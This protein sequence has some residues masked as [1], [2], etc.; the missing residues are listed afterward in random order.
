MGDGASLH[1]LSGAVLFALLAGGSAS[2]L[3]DAPVE[4]VIY[5]FCPQ[6]ANGSCVDGQTPEDGVIMDAS[7]NLYGIT[8]LGGAQNRGTVYKLTSTASG[9]DETVLY[10]F[11]G[12]GDD[13]QSTAGLVM[14]GS[15]NLYWTSGNL[16]FELSPNGT[17]WAEKVI[18]TFP[19][20]ASGASPRIALIDGLGSL[21][22][23]TYQGGI[24]TSGA[25]YGAGTA[26]KMTPS[27]T[28][29]TETVLYSFCQKTNCA[30][31]ANPNALLGDTSGNFYGTT[32]TGGAYGAG[33]VFKL[34][35]SGAA[36]TETVLYSFC[37]QT[38]CP[39][40]RG[41]ANLLMDGAGNLYGTAGNGGGSRANGTV[42]MLA[43]SGS[44]W[45][46]TVLYNFACNEGRANGLV[47]DPAG[48]LYGTTGWVVASCSSYGEIYKLT[49]TGSGWTQTII[50]NPLFPQ[51]GLLADKSGNIYGTA[52]GGYGFGLCPRGCG[53][54]YE[55][56]SSGNLPPQALSVSIGGNGKGSLASSPA[57]I[58]C[59]APT[60]SGDTCSAN[61]PAGTIVTLSASS[62]SGSSFAGWSGACA[63]TGSCQVTMNQ[64][65]T[66]SATF[67]S[68][69]SIASLA[70]SLI[71]RG[72]V[73]SSPSGISCPNTC[74]ASYAA[75]SN[76][77]LTAT[78]ANGW[79]FRGWSG[80]CSGT[81]ACSV[82]M[83]SNQSAS[84]T[85][86]RWRAGN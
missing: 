81:D 28:G 56:T 7:G 32:S 18:Y 14:D 57:G 73:T 29:W 80:A 6:G 30:D 21:Y 69:N 47:M 61:F 75:G 24:Q 62:Q 50:A 4:E 85:F 71:G 17:G 42:F 1:L 49:K 34:S 51:P 68:A 25:P 66:V 41:P 23:T 13:G 60:Q 33:T 54:V 10:N 52:W 8:G 84:A 58:V 22:G 83:A 78:A 44:G 46:A 38:G 53:I 36:W 20:G 63:G 3:A 37:P 5:K 39:D 27:G 26:F 67:N 55:V 9:W 19:G 74:T 59:N 79:R 70:V 31:G 16:V 77:T 12:G 72:S 40:G 76:V 15:G 11:S 48:N 45:T 43:P 64:A 35:P 82:T 86:T 2:A 65:Q